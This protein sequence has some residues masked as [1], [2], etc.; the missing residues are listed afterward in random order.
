MC[1]VLN[2]IEVD[3]SDYLG[4]FAR[5]FSLNMLYLTFYIYIYIYIYIYSIYIYIYIRM[6]RKYIY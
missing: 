4:Y 5:V 2:Y 6:D 3:K 1:I